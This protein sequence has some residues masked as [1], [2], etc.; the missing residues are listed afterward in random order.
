[1]KKFRSLLV[2]TALSLTL[3]GGAAGAV[4]AQGHVDG[5]SPFG[6]ECVSQ[7]AKMHEGGV[8]PHIRGMH[9]GTSVG[10]HLQEMRT[11]SHHCGHH[12]DH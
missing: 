8:G 9:S 5:P 11:G 1:M 3:L 4:N 6:R 12:M 2:G 7:I 10:A